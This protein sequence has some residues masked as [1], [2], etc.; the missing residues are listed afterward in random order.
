MKKEQTVKGKYQKLKV[1]SMLIV[2]LIL[3]SNTL[4]S[5]IIEQNAKRT[6]FDPILNISERE[7]QAK[8]GQNATAIE[9]KIAVVGSFN[10]SVPINGTSQ[11]NVGKVYVFE[12]LS[13]VWEVVQVLT[14]PN[15][16]QGQGFG[17]NVALYSDGVNGYIA[18]QR[19]GRRVEIFKLSSGTWTHTQTITPPPPPP[20]APPTGTSNQRDGFGGALAIDKDYLAIGHIH[21]GI[22]GRVHMYELSSSGSTTWSHQ[23]SLELTDALNRP[24]NQYF[25]H[26]VALHGDFLIVGARNRYFGLS[27][28][29]GGG[30]FI[31]KKNGTNWSSS[32]AGRL[33][34]PIN[35]IEIGDQHG[36]SVSITEGLAIVST[37]FKASPIFNNQDKSGIAYIFKNN[38]ANSGTTNDWILDQELTPPNQR[39]FEKFGFSSDI[40]PDYAI[41]GAENDVF[42]GCPGLILNTGSAYVYRPSGNGNGGGWT[43]IQKLFSNDLNISDHY[44]NTVAIDGDNIMVGAPWESE[45]NGGLNTLLKSGSVYF[46]NITGTPGSPLRVSNRNPSNLSDETKES[47]H[48]IN[49]ISPLI[50]E[51]KTDIFT[52]T[53]ANKENIKITLTS[54]T[55][56]DAEGLMELNVMNSLG[57]II[58]NASISGNSSI[59]SIDSQNFAVG[60]YFI[61]VKSKTNKQVE[62]VMIN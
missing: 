30:A 5:Q 9:G 33:E 51:D 38:E 20:P 35:N 19:S 52:I 13:G 56:E 54:E 16:A 42:D 26:D 62:K 29:Y 58:Y 11:S 28:D 18:A 6:A 43:Y 59:I 34:L 27:A 57:Q 60:V 55:N 41:V 61:E 40:S 46:Y 23:V 12:K 49:E 47:T 3:V 7:L 2:L 1:V 48:N 45:D 31:Y 14:A 17:R 32:I 37:P 25:G 22:H 8:F 10:A 24:G 21:A 36:Y 39:D 4:Q 15:P 50:M 44:G 53:R